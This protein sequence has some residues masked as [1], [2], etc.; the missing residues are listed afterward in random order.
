MMRAKRGRHRGATKGA[1]EQQAQR[2][3]QQSRRCVHDASLHDHH[4]LTYALAMF[5]SYHAQASQAA[6]PAEVIACAAPGPPTGSTP[7]SHAQAGA[8]GSLVAFPSL[9]KRAFNACIAKGL[10]VA[11]N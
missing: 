4:F 8:P 6:S 2:A 5:T 3:R 1:R 10:S 9:Q 7:L 11:C